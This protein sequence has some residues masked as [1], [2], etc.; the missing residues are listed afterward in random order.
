MDSDPALDLASFRLDDR[1]FT[2][3]GSVGDHF[4]GRMVFMRSAIVSFGW[5]WGRFLNGGAGETF[6]KLHMFINGAVIT[7]HIKSDKK[8]N[9]FR[10]S[11]KHR[12]IHLTQELGF[13]AGQGR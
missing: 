11:F 13:G 4:S 3:R 1:T 5:S 6:Y 2:V 7:L 12:L 10:E 9:E 8:V